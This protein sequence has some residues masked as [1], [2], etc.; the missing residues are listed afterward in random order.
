MVG[1]GLG[2]MAAHAAGPPVVVPNVVLRKHGAPGRGEAVIGRSMRGGGVG[3]I[4]KYVLAKNVKSI[5]ITWNMRT[6]TQHPCVKVLNTLKLDL[7]KNNSRF[8]KN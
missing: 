6:F 2:R 7:L 8:I 3:W 5:H 4:V 1:R